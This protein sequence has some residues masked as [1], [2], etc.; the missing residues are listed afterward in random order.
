MDTHEKFPPFEEEF[1]WTFC[2][3][4]TGISRPTDLHECC[5][6]LATKGFIRILALVNQWKKLE[7]SGS[8]RMLHRK[9]ESQEGRFWTNS[10]F[11]KI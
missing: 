10:Q 9:T 4:H 8:L 3:V 5:R 7:A 6:S 1:D 2:F 11:C